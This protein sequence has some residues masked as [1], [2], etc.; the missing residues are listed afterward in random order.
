MCLAYPLVGSAVQQQQET[1]MTNR[2]SSYPT[3]V[4]RTPTRPQP[5]PDAL[6]FTVPEVRQLGGPGRTKV[7]ELINSGKLKT[8]MVGGRRLING[9]SFRDLMTRGETI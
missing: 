1:V 6:G 3:K 4:S 8:V 7:Y 9:D 5:R 2:N